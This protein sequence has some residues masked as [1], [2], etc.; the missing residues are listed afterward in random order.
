M[1]E[2][3]HAASSLSTNMLKTEVVILGAQLNLVLQRVQV[4]L[5]VRAICMFLQINSSQLAFSR[6][7]AKPLWNMLLATRLFSFQETQ[8]VRRGFLYCAVPAL[9]LATC[10]LIRGLCLVGNAQF[11][12]FCWDN[13]VDE[14]HSLQITKIF[15]PCAVRGIQSLRNIIMI[16]RN[17]LCAWCF[18]WSSLCFQNA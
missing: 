13:V 18:I 3:L 14:Q 11:L 16:N 6:L 2:T 1:P 10:C 4:D 8:S 17:I 9:L 15:L 5:H 7:V 12:F